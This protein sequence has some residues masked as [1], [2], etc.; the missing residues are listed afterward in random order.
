MRSSPGVPPAQIAAD[1]LCKADWWDLLLPCLSI[2]DRSLLLRVREWCARMEE[3]SRT[4]VKADVVSY[5]L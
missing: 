3:E 2:D 4:L 5:I 1:G